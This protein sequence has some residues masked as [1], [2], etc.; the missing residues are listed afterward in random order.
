MLRPIYLILLLACVSSCNAQRGQTESLAPITH[1]K[2]TE[3]LQKHVSDQGM[4]DYQGFE[5]ERKSLTAYLDLIRSTAPNKTW[6]KEEEIAYWINAYNAFTIELVLRHYPVNSI[7]D[8]GN[9]I[10]IPFVNTPWDIKFIEIG[11]ET[12]DLNNIE[13]SILRDKWEEPRVHFALNCASYSCPILRNE[14]YEADVLDQQLDEQAALFINDDFRN[15]ITS[16]QANLSKIFSWFSGDFNNVM[17]VV[18]FINQYADVKITD[19]TE[20]DYK[21]Y[22]WR[23]NDAE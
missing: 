20:I 13:H 3:L 7:K 5:A 18:D 2:F 14:A 4:V 1:E 16:D 15:D 6:T 17:P 9:S 12:Y 19:D 11:G 10:Q 21:D 22:D 23:L 8:I